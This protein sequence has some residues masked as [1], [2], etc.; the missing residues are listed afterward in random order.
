MKLI[1]T[2]FGKNAELLIIKTSGIYTH[3]CAKSVN[4]CSDKDIWKLLHFQIT[5]F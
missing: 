3:H 5:A 4:A 2:H 1:I